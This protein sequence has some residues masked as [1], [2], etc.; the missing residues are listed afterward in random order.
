MARRNACGRWTPLIPPT[1]PPWVLSAD[2]SERLPDAFNSPRGIEKGLQASLLTALHE[3]SD[4]NLPRLLL[5]NDDVSAL[6]HSTSPFGRVT[7]F[8]HAGSPDL[9]IKLVITAGLAIID[10]LYEEPVAFLMVD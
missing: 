2:T 7:F 6:Q 1:C 4:W 9:D 10:C 3:N 5:V 8:T